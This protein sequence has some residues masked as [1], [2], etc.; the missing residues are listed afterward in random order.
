MPTFIGS[1]RM[2]GNCEH[3]DPEWR[4]CKLTFIATVKFFGCCQFEPK[5]RDANE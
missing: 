3:Y 2:C 4:W 1:D 5:R